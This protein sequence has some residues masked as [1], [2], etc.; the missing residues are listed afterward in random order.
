MKTD[1][2]T[3]SKIWVYDDGSTNPHTIRILHEHPLIVDG[4][5]HVI[6]ATP[7]KGCKVS[8][9]DLLNEMESQNKS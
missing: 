1:R 8:Y 6:K 7:N 9:L 4:E 2:K 3:I 5:I